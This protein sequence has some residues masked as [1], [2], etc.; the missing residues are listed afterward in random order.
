MS[1]RANSILSSSIVK[2]SVLNIF[3]NGSRNMASSPPKVKID[4]IDSAQIVAKHIERVLLEKQ[5]TSS[6]KEG[7]HHFYV[8]DFT[9]SFQQSTKLFFEEEVHLELYKIWD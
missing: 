2:L 9:N 6:K 8:S 4:V 1:I 5:L 3:E 7:V